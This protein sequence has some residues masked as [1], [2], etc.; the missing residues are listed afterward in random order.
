M[1][2]RTL[3]HLLLER[4]WWFSLVVAAGVFLVFGM[5]SGVIGAAAASPF[6]GVALYGL[7]L[8]IRNGPTAD[9]GDLLRALRAA[10]AE[11]VGDLMRETF[12]RQGYQLTDTPEGDLMLDRNGYKTLVRYRR[13][14]AQSTGPQAIE[15]LAGAMRKRGADRGM[16]VATGI[17]ADAAGPAAE[18]AGVTLIDGIA[19]T[20]LLKFARGAHRMIERHRAA[21]AEKQ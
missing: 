20:G 9:P 21:E 1:P 10:S 5:F 15:E 4:P 16:H 3:F 19:L 11:E 6:V 7:Y 8:R 14:K 13:W 17:F 12:G 2:K 18:K